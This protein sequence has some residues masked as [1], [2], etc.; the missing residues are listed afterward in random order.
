MMSLLMDQWSYKQAKVQPNVKLHPLLTIHLYF[1]PII[2]VFTPNQEPI[3]KISSLVRDKV[4]TRLSFVETAISK[5]EIE[6]PNYIFQRKCSC[7][8]SFFNVSVLAEGFRIKILY[9][10]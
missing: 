9:T 4:W 3:F 7:V 8:R 2:F 5:I 1:A 6:V 10:L